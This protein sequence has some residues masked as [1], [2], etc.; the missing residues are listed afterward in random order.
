[1]ASVTSSCDMSLPEP[2]DEHAAPRASTKASAPRRTMRSNCRRGRIAVLGLQ[3]GAQALGSSFEM[4]LEEA[5]HEVVR[6]LQAGSVAQLRRA[7]QR[8]QRILV[9][10][11]F[12]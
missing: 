6:A 4:H 5:R 1:M 3:E 11:G 12:L 10:G 2:V 9:G 7:L 8:G